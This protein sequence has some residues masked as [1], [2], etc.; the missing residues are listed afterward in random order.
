[1]F[2]GKPIIG[3]AGGIGSGKST[4]ARLF[5]QAGCLVLSADEAVRRLYRDNDVKQTLKNWWGEQVINGQNEVDR[6]EVAQI[7]FHQPKEKQR[8]EKLLHPGVTQLREQAMKEASKNSQVLAFIWDIPLLFETGLDSQCDAVVYVETPLEQRLARVRQT[9]GW[10][11]AELN[12][13][14][15][16]QQPLDFKRRMSKYIVQNTADVGFASKQVR[17]VLSAILANN[18]MKARSE[19]T[20]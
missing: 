20:D 16:L 7:V 3:I 19:V 11:E 9:R 12:I 13:R 8:L 15:N 4:I 14:E 17:E 1:M 18:A 2:A 10:D 6:H 5:G